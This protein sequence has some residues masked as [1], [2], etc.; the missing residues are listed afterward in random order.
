MV[1][2]LANIFDKSSLTD[3][4]PFGETTATILSI[5]IA[6][7]GLIMFS[8]FS[9]DSACFNYNDWRRNAST[10]IIFVLFVGTFLYTT[11]FIASAYDKNRYAIVGRLI[12][13]IAVVG[14]L[15]IIALPIINLTTKDETLFNLGHPRQKMWATVISAMLVLGSTLPLMSYIG[16]K[17]INPP[18]A[19]IIQ[20]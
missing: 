7:C 9:Q 10:V 18:Q 6:V 17:I 14:I 15:S 4:F 8:Y 12:T 13:L 19:T 11:P 20:L 3:P 2:V 1:F 5:I 16:Q